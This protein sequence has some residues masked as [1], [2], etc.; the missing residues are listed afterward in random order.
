[1]KAVYRLCLPL[2]MLLLIAPAWGDELYQF[3]VTNPGGVQPFSFQF[4]SPTFITTFGPLSFSPFQITDGTNTFTITQGV[5]G[6]LG[7]G[8]VCFGFG[9]AGDSLSA[10]CASGVVDGAAGFAFAFSGSLP[11][12]VGT[13]NPTSVNG[14]AF[15]TSGGQDPIG[16]SGTLTI[17]NTAPEPSSLLLLSISL[18]GGIAALRRKFPT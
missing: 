1:M 16:G 8:F 11:A 5:S 15:T 18:I 7:A 6:D 12:A 4:T 2:A 9:S 10:N 13:Y 17:S 3:S 14:L